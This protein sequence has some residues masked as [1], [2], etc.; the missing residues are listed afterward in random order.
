MARTIFLPFCCCF[1]LHK[2]GSSIHRY[3]QTISNGAGTLTYANGDTYEGEWRNDSA[4]GYGVLIYANGCRYEGG[5][6]DDR[7]HGQG[8]LYLPDGS[9]SDVHF[10]CSSL[11]GLL[12]MGWVGLIDSIYVVVTP[13]LPGVGVFLRVGWGSRTPLRDGV[14]HTGQSSQR[15][16]WKCFSIVFAIFV[17]VLLG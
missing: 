13:P 11:G 1:I 14:C 5:W 9:Q 4:C 6:L 3:L 10:T 2:G 16:D 8:T 7:R 15:P 17:W 12:R